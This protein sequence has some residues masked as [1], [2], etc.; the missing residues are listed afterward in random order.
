M[1]KRSLNS[2]D[3]P[4]AV[5]CIVTI[6]YPAKIGILRSENGFDL[7]GRCDDFFMKWDH[8]SMTGQRGVEKLQNAWVWSKWARSK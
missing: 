4:V 7:V 2:L 3:Q 8:S 1:I 6:V 5:L